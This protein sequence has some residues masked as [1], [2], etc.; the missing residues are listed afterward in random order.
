M[1]P[2]APTGR[3]IFLGHLKRLNDRVLALHASLSDV[4]GIDN[5]QLRRQIR[6]AY[7]HAADPEGR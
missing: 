3:T 1:T 2:D 4:V 6:E 7:Q 5:K